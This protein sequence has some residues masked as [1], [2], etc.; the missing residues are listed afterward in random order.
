MIKYQLNC[1]AGHD[2]E[3]WFSSG[4]AFETQ[5]KRGLV[6]CAHCGSIKVDSVPS[7]RRMLHA[8]IIIRKICRKPG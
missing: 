4:D 5:K 7:W 6:E 8:P 1:D 2:F 3:A